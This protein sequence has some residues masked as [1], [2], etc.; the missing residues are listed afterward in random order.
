MGDQFVCQWRNKLVCQWRFVR[1]DNES[2]D[3]NKQSELGTHHINLVNN[4][5]YFIDHLLCIY[6][7]TDPLLL[8]VTVSLHCLLLGFHSKGFVL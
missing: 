5:L 6:P 1:A 3:S 2:E 7:N 8:E 4:C